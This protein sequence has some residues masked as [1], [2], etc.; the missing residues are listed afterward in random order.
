MAKNTNINLR[1]SVIYQVFPRQHSNK[2]N[3]LGVIEDLDRIKDLGCD[4]LYL[5]PIH[6]IGQ[7]NK[8]GSLGCPYS[9]YNY[10]EVNKDL[11]TL[12]DFKKLIEE[13][14]NRNMKI[15]I[16]VVYNHTSRDSYLLKNHPEWFYRNENNEFANRVGD[17]WDVT[18]LDY[19]KE[20]L[21]EELISTLVYWASLGVEGFR[22]DVAALVPLD[23]WI[24][25][26]KELIKVNKD[27]ILFAESV[28]PG[29]VKYIRDCGFEAASD[30]ELY[31]AFDIEYDY[32][33]IKSYRNYLRNNGPLNDWL[34]SLINQETMY[35]KNFIK[36]HGLEN[37]DNERSAYY[38][39]DS[40]K[41]RNLN[42]LTYFLKGTTFIYAGQEALDTKQESLFDVDLIDWS[43]LGKYDLVNL[44]KKCYEIKKDPLFANG[45]YNIILHDEEI[46]HLTYESSNEELVCICNLGNLDKEILCEMPDGE[47]IN[48]FDDTNISIVNGYIKLSSNP[49]V[50]KYNK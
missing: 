27:I 11:G 40:V 18:D 32:D 49:I 37:H 50:I 31:E 10:K 20:G 46:A 41:I 23:F 44:M 36:A 15:M 7:K 17:W 4:I 19:T 28:E 9:I 34:N 2:S 14:H 22:C 26:R 16:D 42:A 35:P 1:N 33:I 25:A 48:I 38:I 39:K 24:E 3:F 6:P 47:Y 5:L 43:N 29:F 21:K 8:K 30:A 45:I 12:D 13:T